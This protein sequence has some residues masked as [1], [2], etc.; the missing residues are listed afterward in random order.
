MSGRRVPFNDIGNTINPRGSRRQENKPKQA[1]ASHAAYNA[2]AEQPQST[3]PLQLTAAPTSPRIDDI[4]RGD[5]LHVVEYLKEIMEHLRSVEDRRLPTATYM[6]RQTDINKKMRAIL[7]DW[8]VD[9][10]LK[11]KLLPETLYLAVGLIDRFLDKKVVTRQ[12]LQ[13]VGV[14]AMFLGAKYEEIYPPEIKDFIY[15][16]A[17]TYTKDEI[18][19]MELMMLSTLQFGLTVPTIY[20]FVKRGL[21]IVDADRTCVH[22]ALYIAEL[23]L[24]EYDLISIL[25][26]T[27]AAG[28]VYLA[29]KILQKTEPWNHM[30][31]HYT[32]Y[33]MQ[34]ADFESCV[35][36]LYDL[37]R[38]ARTHKCQAIRK[39]YSYAKYDGVSELADVDLVLP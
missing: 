24:L 1:V 21:Q 33:D 17:N 36:Q 10:H 30:L 23:S 6:E 5:Q 12:R 3:S 31:E 11:F 2:A 16:S 14:V 13:L 29:R 26:S 32:S 27:I 37:V 25:P 4:R 22:M 19:R 28:C 35:R 7:V 34:D 15:I 38:G 8:L 9:V 20:P 18:L 39:K